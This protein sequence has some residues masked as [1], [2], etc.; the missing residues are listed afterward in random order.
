MFDCVVVGERDMDDEL[1]PA[2]L[3]DV[4]FYDDTYIAVVLQTSDGEGVLA[5]SKTRR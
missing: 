4:Q 3:L 2:E 5:L 1:I